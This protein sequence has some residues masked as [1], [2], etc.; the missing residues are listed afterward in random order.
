YNKGALVFD[1]LSREIGRERFQQILAGLTRGRHS[2][3][4]TWQAFL[5]ACREG[6]GRKLDWFFDQWLHRAGA[7]DFQLSWHPEKAGVRAV[8]PQQKPCYRAHLTIEARGSHGERATRVVE[9]TGARASASIAPGFPVTD[10]VLDPDYEI[11][12]WTPEY[13]DLARAAGT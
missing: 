5:D 7:P 12:R 11:L 1:M 13:R 3:T 8:I 9:I 10:V 2:E 6:S 4:M